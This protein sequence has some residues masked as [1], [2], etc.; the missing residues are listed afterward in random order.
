MN[1]RI[2]LFI[3]VIITFSGC[4]SLRLSKGDV[5][6]LYS[7]VNSEGFLVPVTYDYAIVQKVD[8]KHIPY[9]ENPIF[10]SPGTHN[11]EVKYGHCFAPVLIIM[12]DLQS[13]STKVVEG[14]FIGGRK[15]R[16]DINN[17]EIIEI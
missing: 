12:C 1:I 11:I 13:S 8:G 7:T 15:Y 3:A 16:L 6:A 10:I 4:T 14:E 9:D 2:T 17:G 5:A